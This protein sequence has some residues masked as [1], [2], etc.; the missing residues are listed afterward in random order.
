M[1]VRLA[2]RFSSLAAVAAV[3]ASASVAHAQQITQ[4]TFLFRGDCTDCRMAHNQ[5]VA[6]DDQLSRY[7]V[8]GTLTLEVEQPSGGSPAVARLLTFRYEPT[9]LLPDGVFVDAR[10]NTILEQGFAYT[11][12][13]LSRAYF[14]WDSGFFALGGYP[15]LPR[16]GLDAGEWMLCFN[17]DALA[18][19]SRGD[20]PPEVN[21]Y[22]VDGRFLRQST[23]VPEP[24]SIV[25]MA[26]GLGALGFA[27]RRRAI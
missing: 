5:S 2:F 1:L 24:N 11:G 26:A 18:C 8:T 25:L 10:E 9:N 19:L 14:S 4:E 7:L 21:D 16:L 23:T 22:G 27:A 15:P 20:E 3:L 6:P 13:E 12:G 17:V